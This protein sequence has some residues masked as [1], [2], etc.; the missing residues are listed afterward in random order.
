MGIPVGKL[1]LTE[2]EKRARN[3][4]IQRKLRADARAAK[5]LKP[6]NKQSPELI[7]YH[8]KYREEHKE[9]IAVQQAASR[10]QRAVKS[11]DRIA[12]ALAQAVATE[13]NVSRIVD[14]LD[15]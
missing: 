15:E 6:R 14:E 10:K 7:A 8:K 3:T 1:S 9:I 13:R 2:E 5:N 11:K 4:A 12:E